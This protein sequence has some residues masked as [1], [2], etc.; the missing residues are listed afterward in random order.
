MLPGWFT[1][2]LWW[3]FALTAVAALAMTYFGSYYRISRAEQNANAAAFGHPVLFY[4]PVSRL[5]ADDEQQ[6]KDAWAEHHRLASFYGPANW[7]DQK[8]FG[9]S[10]PSRGMITGLSP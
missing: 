3:L 8:F 4:V 10:P 5:F 2:R 7:I 9:G 6:Y 1:F